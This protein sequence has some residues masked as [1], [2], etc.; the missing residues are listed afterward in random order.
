MRSGSF[1][2]GRRLFSIEENDSVPEYEIR[3]KPLSLVTHGVA[4]SAH[5]T[6][7]KVVNPDDTVAIIIAEAVGEF[8]DGSEFTKEDIEIRPRILLE[9]SFWLDS[10]KI[11]STQDLAKLN[12]GDLTL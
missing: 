5:V 9:N 10:G 8:K 1:F 6:L 11:I 12:L 2:L 4:I 7:K 3:I